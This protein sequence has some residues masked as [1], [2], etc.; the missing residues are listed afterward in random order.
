MTVDELRAEVKKIK[1]GDAL[2]ILDGYLFN[3]QGTLKYV[4][5]SAEHKL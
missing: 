5:A 2:E 4:S 1:R 3:S